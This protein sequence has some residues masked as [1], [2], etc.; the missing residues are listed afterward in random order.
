MLTFS[1]HWFTYLYIIYIYNIYNYI[2]YLFEYLFIFYFFQEPTD[3]PSRKKIN[4]VGVCQRLVCQKREFVRSS[5]C[6]VYDPK[7][8]NGI[9]FRIDMKHSYFFPI[10]F[11]VVET[12]VGQKLIHV[13]ACS[14]CIK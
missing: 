12:I 14:C 3:I 11:S 8:K 5:S 2:L 9:Y 4:E 6:E 10:N 1:N 13:Y 7:L